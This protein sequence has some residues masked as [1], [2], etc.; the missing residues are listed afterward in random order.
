MVFTLF[1]C[2]PMR[3]YICMPMRMYVCMHEW[4]RV[5]SKAG[6]PTAEVDK[7]PEK[8]SE[9]GATETGET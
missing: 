2:M 9:T 4:T 5:Y 6:V 8:V 1:I 3:M 7:P